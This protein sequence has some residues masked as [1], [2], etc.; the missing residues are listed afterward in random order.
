MPCGSKSGNPNHERF[1]LTPKEFI[2]KESLSE[3]KGLKNK[4]KQ[5]IVTS[6]PRMPCGG[7][8]GSYTLGNWTVS[9]R[10]DCPSEPNVEIEDP[11]GPEPLPGSHN[12]ASTYLHTHLCAEHQN[13]NGAAP[14]ILLSN[15]MLKT[16][17]LE[18]RANYLEGT[19]K[20]HI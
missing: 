6:Q 20:K 15:G 19:R 18:I 12:Q 13:T 3:Q 10:A 9:Q 16:M 8:R 17:S 5:T 4:C 7:M 1:A 14:L 2:P 11:G